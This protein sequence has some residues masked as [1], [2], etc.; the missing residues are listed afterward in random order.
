MP[1]FFITFEG[2]D[3]AGKTTQIAL[4]R[5]ELEQNGCS[6]CV[7][8]EP[9]GDP[10]GERVRDLLLHA[11]MDPRAELLLF[12][13]S[14]AQNTAQVIRP[15]LEAGGIVLCDRYID[16]SVAYQG[17]ARGLGIELVARLNAFATDG[18]TPDLTFLLDL[19]PAAGLARQ[20]ARNRME[21]QGL[22]F[23][24]KVREG[25]LATAANN[26]ARF[27]VFD[28]SLSPDTL[29]DAISAEVRL[30]LSVEGQCRRENP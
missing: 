18:L 8:R 23:Q 22:E 1:G 21:A 28:A 7:T 14:R 26:A 6:V 11:D 15:H 2:G 10:V 9:G 17:H 27:R 24:Q 20:V 4:L 30:R 16:S 3:G 29:H 5:H 19:D 12:L 13:A 25:F